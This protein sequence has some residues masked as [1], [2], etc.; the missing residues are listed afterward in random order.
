MN[1]GTRK[2]NGE[3]TIYFVEKLDGWRKVY[4]VLELQGK[5][6]GREYP[7]VR[8]HTRRVGSC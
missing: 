7:C 5:N 4:R 2:S 3:G 1:K 6:Q 8:S